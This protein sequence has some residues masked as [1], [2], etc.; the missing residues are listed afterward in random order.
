M[1]RRATVAIGALVVAGITA[2]P[3]LAKGHPKPKPKPIKGTW[4]FTDTTPDPTYA[5]T[6]LND[7]SMHCHGQLPA[8][9]A[10][11]NAKTI[12]VVGHGTLTVEG[13]SVGDWAMELRDRKG[14]VLT[15][16]DQNPPKQESVSMDLNKG[17]WTLYYCNLTGAPTATATYSFIY[18]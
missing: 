5:G 9:A 16:D 14:N 11:V 1:N 17:S 2:S 4:S 3:A 15:G 10:D 13:N 6:S 8:G 12:T 18:H 7:A